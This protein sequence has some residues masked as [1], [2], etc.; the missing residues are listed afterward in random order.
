MVRLDD[1][2]NIAQH[3]A[4]PSLWVP[5]CIILQYYGTYTLR[6]KAEGGDQE[7]VAFSVQWM[8]IVGTYYEYY[9]ARAP[10]S[11]VLVPWSLVRLLSPPGSGQ[12]SI[13]AS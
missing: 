13:L 12:A 6:N 10:W 8:K 4:P 1:A 2:Q 7:P 11:L 9:V 3:M 5:D